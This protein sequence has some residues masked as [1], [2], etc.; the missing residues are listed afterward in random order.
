MRV[1]GAPTHSAVRTLAVMEPTTPT[2]TVAYVV[3]L[4]AKDDTPAE[5]A[6]LLTGALDLAN[7]EAGTVVWFALRTD[8]TTFWIVDAFATEDDRQTHINGQIAAALMANADRLLAAPPEILPADVL[9]AK[10]P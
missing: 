5:L 9:A 1:R 10:V 7:A 2:L 4:V 3:R 6:D 8:P